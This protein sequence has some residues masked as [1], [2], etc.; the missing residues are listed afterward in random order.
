MATIGPFKLSEALNLRVFQLAPVNVVL[1]LL[2]GPT[3]FLTF[4]WLSPLLKALAK[5]F[6]P[7]AKA[8]SNF[9]GSKLEL[10][11]TLASHL[12]PYPITIIL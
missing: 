7:N 12:I 2:G 10:L 8:S 6:L 4:Y 11:H 3:A 9:N 5:H 1:I